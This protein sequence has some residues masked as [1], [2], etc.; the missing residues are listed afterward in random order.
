MQ[1]RRFSRDV[2]GA[3]AV[4]FAVLLPFLAFILV[5]AVDWGRI[6]YYSITCENC[7]RNGAMW[8]CDPIIQQSSPYTNVTDASTADASDLSPTPTVTPSTGTDSAGN[9]YCAVTVSYTFTTVTNFPG[10]PHTTSI[11]RTVLMY[12]APLVPN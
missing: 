12:P 4:E 5:I 3:A 8:Y 7:A 6:F 11:T 10:V 1:L 9:P 2:R